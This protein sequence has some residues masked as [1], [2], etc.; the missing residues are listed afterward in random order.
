PRGDKS[1]RIVF[2]GSST[3]VDAHYVPFSHSEFVGHWLNLWTASQGSDVRFEVLN[4][5]RESLVSND[6]RAGCHSGVLP[7]QPALVV[8]YEGGNQFSPASIVDKVPTGTA[9]RSAQAQ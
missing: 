8:Y 6:L 5:G 1:V 2:V 3:V 7:L 9:V 4:A